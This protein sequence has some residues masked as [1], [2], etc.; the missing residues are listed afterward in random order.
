MAFG[1]NWNL[2]H[3]LRKYWSSSTVQF[4]PWGKFGYRMS[5]FVSENSCTYVLD[6]VLCFWGID[7]CQSRIKTVYIEKCARLHSNPDQKAPTWP[8]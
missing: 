8:I 7:I 6:F 4:Q 2:S 3:G 1:Y 5:W